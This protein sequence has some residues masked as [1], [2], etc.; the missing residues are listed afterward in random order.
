MAMQMAVL[1]LNNDYLCGIDTRQVKTVLKYTEPEILA[2][3]PDFTEGTINWQNQ[4]VVVV[5]LNKR[6]SGVSTEIT[7]DTKIIVTQ[8]DLGLLGLIVNDI[9]RIVTIQEGSDIRDVPQTLFNEGLNF[10][11]SIVRDNGELVLVI[12]INRILTEKER[13]MLI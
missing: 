8:T 2:E 5:D 4:F 3:K 1:G 9:N 11:S 13:E 10:Y 6:L 12:D 7:K